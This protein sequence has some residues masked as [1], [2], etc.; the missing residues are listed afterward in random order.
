[1]ATTHDVLYIYI[2]GDCFFCRW[3]RSYIQ[4]QKT[5]IRYEIIDARK[6]S[7]QIEF[8]LHKGYAIDDGMIIQ[9]DTQIYQGVDALLYIQRCTSTHH[10]WRS[11]L[12]HRLSI[13]LYTLMNILRKC[14]LFLQ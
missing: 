10:I 13:P 7:S 9:H 5:N 4:L 12:L 14:I 6:A 8:F 2:D 3:Y 1:M 11:P